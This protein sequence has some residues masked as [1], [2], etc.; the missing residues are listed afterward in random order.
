MS[1]GEFVIGGKGRGREG[2]A[3]YWRGKG[4]ARSACKER[5]MCKCVRESVV[6]KCVLSNES[7]LI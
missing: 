1:A 5:G 4:A 3:S 7:L 6:W 2:D